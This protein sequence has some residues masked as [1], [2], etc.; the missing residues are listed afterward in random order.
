MYQ[1]HVQEK[2]VMKDEKCVGI[3]L[4]STLGLARA[5][6]IDRI[7]NKSFAHIKEKFTEQN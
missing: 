4:E 2:G 7:K 1:I 6:Y 3:I 5:R